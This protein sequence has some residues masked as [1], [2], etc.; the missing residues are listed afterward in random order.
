[1]TK[2]HMSEYKM[3]TYL[4][5]VRLQIKCTIIAVKI[6]TYQG[7]IAAKLTDSLIILTYHVVSVQCCQLGCSQNHLV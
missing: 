4:P 3:N 5:T 1:V 6:L 2:R 7:I